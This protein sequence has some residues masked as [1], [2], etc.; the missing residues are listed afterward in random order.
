M[1][2]VRLGVNIDHVAT[3]RNARGGIHP[4]PVQSAIIAQNAGADGITAHLR[5]DRRHISDNDI[6]RLKKE[7]NL[8]L[9]LEMAATNEM[10]QIALKTKPN[11]ACIV[12]E[13]RAELTTEG[14]LDVIKNEKKLVKIINELKSSQIKISLFVD[15]DLRQIEKSLVI[16]ADIVEIHTGTYCHS[17]AIAKD[18]EFE[19]ISKCAEFATKIG[20]ECHAGH[21]LD[22]DSAAEI[23]KIPQIIEL[24]IGH[25]LIG[26]SIFIGLENAI[27]KMKQFIKR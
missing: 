12:P 23:V 5:E 17:K 20:L 21:G 10:L 14:G 2:K 16:G 7:I 25:F 8:P 4:D 1:N 6:Y 27:K 13:K 24:N 26:E 3:I 22:F 15:P 18:K 19:K 9:N 11:A